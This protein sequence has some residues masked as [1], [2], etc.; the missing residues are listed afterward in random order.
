MNEITFL[1]QILFVF[2]FTYGAFRLGKNALITAVSIQAILANFFVLKQISL[3]GFTVT[4]SDAF[5]IGS[6][7]SLNLLREYFGRE[8]SKKAISICFFFMAFFVV[9]SQMHLRFTPSPFDSA[10]HSYTALLSPAPRLLTAS[11]VAFF[12]TQQFDVRCFGWISNVLPKSSFPVR[13][14]ISLGVSQL[15]DTALF[16]FI[17]L[18]G[19]VESLFDIIVI[20]FLLKFVII[21][22]LGPLTTI[23]KRLAPD[24]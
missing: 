19:L 10:H 4:C 1:L 3:L 24:V 8:E 2:L 18:F 21:L 20:S 13:S 14:T 5:A 7:L 12:I 9:M 15:L 6:I 17:G 11:L 22:M 16:G 23:F